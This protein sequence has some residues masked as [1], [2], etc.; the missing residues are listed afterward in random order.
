MTSYKDPSAGDGVSHLGSVRIWPERVGG[1]LLVRHAV[2]PNRQATETALRI[3]FLR[4]L[5]RSSELC[6]A[7]FDVR[8]GTDS[9]DGLHCASDQLLVDIVKSVQHHKRGYDVL[10]RWGSNEFLLALPEANMFEARGVARRIHDAILREFPEITVSFGI[11]STANVESLDRIL[12]Q[13]ARD[14][15]DAA[16]P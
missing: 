7:L 2:V 5:R 11:S 3:E 10:G 8:V 9:D 13:A 14:Q 4:S 6:V 12:L 1:P 16:P 15:K